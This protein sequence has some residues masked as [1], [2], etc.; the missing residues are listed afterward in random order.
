[1]SSQNVRAV[2]RVLALAFVAC[3]PG[4]LAAQVVASQA[5]GNANSPAPK[6]DIFVGYS[7][8]DPRGTFNTVQPDG[9]VLPATFNLEKRGLLEEATYYFNRNAGIQVESGQ[10][11]LFTNTGFANKGSSNS[12]ILS[13]S[14][15]L[16]YRWPGM[17]LTPF[18]HGLAGGAH[19]EGP[20]HEPYTW[21]GTLT[22][23]GGLDWYFGCRVGIRLVQADYEFF[24][25]NSH[26]SSGSPAN[27]NFVFGD[28]ENINAFRLSAGLVFR[29]TSALAPA[30]DC[31]SPPPIALVCQAAPSA[32]FPGEPVTITATPSGLNPKLKETYT[33]AGP[34]ASANGNVVAIDTNSLT[35]G[36]YAVRATVTEGTKHT[37]STDCVARFT[38]N[39][40]EPPA[41]ACSA[42]PA[43]IE[44]GQISTILLSGRSPQNLP[45][46]YKCTSTAGSVVIDGNKAAFSIAG[47]PAGPVTIH[48]GV[49]DNQG[50]AAACDT[51][52]TI[53]KP[54]QPPPPPLPHV[55][56][57][58]SIDFGEDPLHPT[59]VNGQA[60]ACLDGIAL[61]LAENPDATLV[62]VVGQATRN[63]MRAHPSTAAQRA[64]NA[65]AY[66]TTAQ[67]IDPSRIVVATGGEDAKVVEDYLVPQGAIFTSDVQGTTPVDESVV[68]PQPPE[69]PAAVAPSATTGPADSHRK[70]GHKK[71][72]AT[73]PIP[74]K[75]PIGP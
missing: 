27:N 65:K 63:E 24:H 38:V 37:Q 43:T 17:H 42:V 20:D 69:P 18:I 25:A 30:S 35:P 72:P 71:K 40:W 6:W 11:D 53:I 49:T 5:N 67:G 50:Q 22:A 15:G 74:P 33:W 48:C 12:G 51:S 28:D 58:C 59:R 4:S 14:S 57:L 61:R 73:A 75:G 29:G 55:R 56:P 46:T 45:L 13:L 8:L 1:M 60:K 66:L 52:I 64:V 62:V 16:I 7:I 54:Q 41:L 26:A 31:G 39:R 68:K 10:H 23:G 9:S 19:V 34:Q 32:V 44:P 3:L 2:S 36:A 47:A 21:G 70:P